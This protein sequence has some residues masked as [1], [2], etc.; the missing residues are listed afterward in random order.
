MKGLDEVKIRVSAALITGL[1]LDQG[2]SVD[3][4]FVQIKDDKL[5]VGLVRS[6]NYCGFRDLPT[7]LFRHC[8]VCGREMSNDTLALAIREK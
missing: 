1:A 8:N 3:E 2:L 4:T 7:S 6:C 5:F